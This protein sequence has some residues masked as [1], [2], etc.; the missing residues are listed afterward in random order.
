MM[1]QEGPYTKNCLI[2]HNHTFLGEGNNP[3]GC[4]I[5]IMANQTPFGVVGFTI[6]AIFF[7]YLAPCSPTKA[8]LQMT[9]DK[10]KPS[11]FTA[12]GNAIKCHH[13]LPQMYMD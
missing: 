3:K 6:I 8:I 9:T 2:G 13:G 12:A 10:A 7:W 1:V 4:L 5:V 11:G